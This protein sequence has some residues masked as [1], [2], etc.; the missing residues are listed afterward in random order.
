MLRRPC[1]R[2]TYSYAIFAQLERQA[3]R[4]ARTMPLLNSVTPASVLY[5]ELN[6]RTDRSAAVQTEPALVR[7]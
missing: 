4:Y 3:G 5:G 7:Y 2:R 1:T 6:M